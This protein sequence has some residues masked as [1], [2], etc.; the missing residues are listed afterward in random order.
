MA[1]NTDADSATER[2]AAVHA[3]AMKRMDAIWQVERDNRLQSKNDRRF[4]AIRGAQWAGQYALAQPTDENGTPLDSGDARMEVNKIGRSVRRIRSEYRSAKKS[5]DFRP[6]GG[7][8]KT[9]NALDGLYRSD[10]NDSAGGG[11]HAYDI[12]FGEGS[13]GGYGGWRYRADYEDPGD[14]GNEHQRIRIEPIHDADQSLFFDLDAKA[15]D[16][17]DAR[18]AFLLFTMTRDRFEEDQPDHSP[19]TFTELGEQEWAYDWTRADDL[20]LA[21]YFEA[22][23]HSVVRVTFRQETLEGVDGVDAGEQTVDQADLDEKRDDGATTAE[24]LKAQGF[25]EVKRRKVERQRVRK[26]LLSGTEVLDDEGYIAGPNIPL[27]PYYFEREYI[28]G[29]EQVK[30]AVRDGIDPQRIY[31]V[32]ISSMTDAAAGPSEPIPI[33]TTDQIAG[34]EQVWADRKV[35]RPAFLPI[36]PNLD[37]DGNPVSTA[38]AGMIEPAQ[39]APNVAALMAAAGADI[40]ELMGETGNPATVPANTSAQAIELV[41]DRGDARDFLWSDNFST[42]LERGG[43]IWLGMASELYVEEGREMI[44]IGE[45][46]GQSTVTLA[47]TIT[48]EEHGD[49]VLN[50]FKAGRYDVVVDVGPAT[51]TRRDA[52]AK[53]MQGIA[54]QA[55]TL[56]QAGVAEGGQIA[57]AALGTAIT[58]YDGEGTDGIK[59][60]VRKLGVQ[61]GW[62]EP[63]PEEQKALDEAAAQPQQPDPNMIAAQAQLVLAQAE[64]A[65]AETGRIEAQARMIS[66]QASAEKSR[67]DAIAALAG[68]DQKDRELIIREV[69]AGLD[70]DRADT[71]QQLRAVTAAHAAERHD[72]DMQDARE[73]INGDAAE[74]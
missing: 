23:D 5:V 35:N 27:V 68:I 48:D 59:K 1:A 61:A 21:E 62:L 69:S 17:S 70:S 64:Q 38:V 22:E 11:V 32:M 24:W 6:K 31:N 10:E 41:N 14:E 51:K 26:Y 46:G 52:T 45:D 63:T 54:A 36:N 30:G 47:E 37:N 55:G 43:A 44:A 50:D 72:R 34:H 67:A 28:D 29:V 8:D 25:V 2:L 66:A 13:G 40:N 20:T 42:A 4:I 58:Q 49:R 74:R 56:A 12:A 39:V 60:W 9:A 73:P 3:R 71:D 53:G 19:S 18:H 65:K 7:G 33:V 16:K 57:L 15:P